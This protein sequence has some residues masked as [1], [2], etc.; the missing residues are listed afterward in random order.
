MF[1]N[2]HIQQVSSLCQT[3]SQFSQPTLGDR[4]YYGSSWSQT[5]R[6]CN[7]IQW[8][9]VAPAAEKSI[10]VRLARWNKIYIILTLCYNWLDTITSWGPSPWGGA[11]WTW[12]SRS[13]PGCRCPCW[14]SWGCRCSPPQRTP[15]R[16]YWRR[17][18]QQRQSWPD[19]IRPHFQNTFN[20][21]LS[22]HN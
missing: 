5:L 4:K 13:P 20:F 19:L 22:I 8:I 1:W 14:P 21:T 7:F 11:G 10:K 3:F 6:H 17:R 18:E 2:R 15:S 16:T 9:S 12:R